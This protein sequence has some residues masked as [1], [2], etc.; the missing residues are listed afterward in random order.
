MRIRLL[1]ALAPILLGGG[2]TSVYAALGD[3]PRCPVPT[4]AR[5][6]SAL[7][8]VSPLVLKLR[9]AVA[10][11]DPKERDYLIRTVAF[12]ASGESDVGKVAVVHVILNRKRTGRWGNTVKAVV[13]HPWQFEPW[14]TKRLEMER[15]SPADPRYRSAARVVD[16]VLKGDEPDP[17]SGAT[18]F[19]NPEI[20]RER[21]GGSLPAWANGDGQS[22]GNHTFYS[23]EGRA[24]PAIPVEDAAAVQTAALSLGILPLSTANPDACNGERL[25]EREPGMPADDLVLHEGAPSLPSDDLVLL[26]IGF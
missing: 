13:T 8:A 17:T 22:I 5:T 12:E 1:F 11:D 3:A 24:K 7:P 20:V 14:M 15:L 18:H 10:N 6:M 26:D 2:A 4:A 19:L 9:Q 23:P 21:R 25:T 16:A